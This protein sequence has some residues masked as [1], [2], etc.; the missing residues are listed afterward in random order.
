MSAPTRASATA[1]GAALVAVAGYASPTALT[2]VVL[3]L[4]VAFA[5]GWP[6]LIDLP[7]N[8]GGSVVIALTAVAAL[9]AARAGS[10]T[11]LTMVMG[12]AVVAAFVHQMMRRDGRPRLVE[13]VSGIVTGCVV[14]LSGAGWAAADYG[15]VNQALVVTAAATIAA[16]AACTAVP[17]PL[18]LVGSLATVVSGGVGVL[19]GSLLDPVGPVPGGLVGLAVGVLTA[20]LHVLFGQFPASRRLRPALAAALL[21]VLAVGVPVYMVG[22]LLEG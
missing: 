22:G 20:A 15:D 1:T 14:V 13:S 17:G 18:R 21:T 16:A 9:L 3:V 5:S 10:V 11:G 4:S 8:R 6:R 19:I 12:L 2:G 7:T